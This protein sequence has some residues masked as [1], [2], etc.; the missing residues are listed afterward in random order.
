MVGWLGVEGATDTRYSH[1]VGLSAILHLGGGI[2]VPAALG[3]SP[4]TMVSSK[5]RKGHLDP[6]CD[7]TRCWQGSTGKG[8][9]RCSLLAG[10]IRIESDTPRSGSRCKRGRWVMPNEL[11]S[12]I[13]PKIWKPKPSFQRLVFCAETG[14]G[15]S[16]R[17]QWRG[18]KGKN[19]DIFR[20]N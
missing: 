4:E 15:R 1:F 5:E 16:V 6:N 2:Y 13:S 9:G 12:P 18:E 3:T 11:L 8:H 7:K 19:P 17:T 14:G 20:C 10:K